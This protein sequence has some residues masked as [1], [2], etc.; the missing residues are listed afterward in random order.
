[1]ESELL[2]PDTYSVLQRECLENTS[3][4][5]DQHII[6]Q[7]RHNKILEQYQK[8]QKQ[9]T[10]PEKE[11]VELSEQIKKNNLKKVKK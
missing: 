3:K 1:M 6:L 5:V 4:F 7:Q 9:Y 10:E 11:N 8:L 2:I